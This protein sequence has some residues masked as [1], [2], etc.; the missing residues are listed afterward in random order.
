MR[1]KVEAHTFSIHVPRSTFE[2]SLFFWLSF[3][4]G[5]PNLVSYLS[6]DGGDLAL[7]HTGLSHNIRQRASRQILHHHP[8][9]VSY[10]VAAG[11]REQEKGWIFPSTVSLISLTNH[12]LWDG[13]W[14]IT[15]KNTLQVYMVVA[16]QRCDHNRKVSEKTNS[17]NC[18]SVP[19]ALKH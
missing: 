2:R 1:T 13:G 17:F 16:E 9:L 10:Q 12:C 3:H 5:C 14:S 4:C 19:A 6:A 8:Q 18:C 15:N 11:W 7:V